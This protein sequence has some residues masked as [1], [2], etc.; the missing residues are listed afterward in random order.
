MKIKRLAAEWHGDCSFEAENTG[1][2]NFKTQMQNSFGFSEIYDARGMK[3]PNYSGY[4]QADICELVRS[5]IYH[6]GT[7][8]NSDIITDKDLEKINCPGTDGKSLM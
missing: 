4:E 3:D 5:L 1:E 6:F 8:S 7:E 2:A